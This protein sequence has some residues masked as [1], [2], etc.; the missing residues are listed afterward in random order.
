M[1]KN[2]LILL[3]VLLFICFSGFSQE[4]FTFKDIPIDGTLDTVAAK[5]EKQG[6][7]ILVQG[8]SVTTLSGEFVNNQ[9]TLILCNSKKSKIVHMII[10]A[11]PVKD[12][13][14]VLKSSYFELKEQYTTKYGKEK[15]VEYFA[16]P[17]NDNSEG[18]EMK[19]VHVGK[20]SFVSK[21][22]TPLGEITILISKE[23]KIN[24][25][26]VDKVN[27]Q[28]NIDEEKESVSNDI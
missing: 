14:S 18:S 22:D 28:I 5:L 8:P 7:K 17:Y 15:S 21:W 1:K 16:Y 10:I 26:Y 4:H 3:T 19:A 23:G 6:F 20:C 9:C 11:L 27:K 13:W 24:I 25:Y 2:K 12:D